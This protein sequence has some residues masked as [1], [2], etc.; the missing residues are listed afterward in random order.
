MAY[1]TVRLEVTGA[2]ATLTIERVDKLNALNVTVRRELIAALDVLAV[3]DQV[4]V[5]VLAGAGD[6]AFAAG[7]DV[8]E[9][10]ARTPDEQ[11]AVMEEYSLFD[12]VA[13]QPKP[14]IA[15]IRGFALGGGCELALACDIRVAARS[16]RLGLPEVR[17]G[18]LPG[19]GGTQR[20]PRLVGYGQALRLILTGD[21][22]DGEEAAHLGLVDVLV[23]DAELE[24]ATADLA[25]AIAA[26]SPVA[27]RAARQAV[28]AAL[29]L[30]LEAGL[31]REREL[32]L[33]AF[34]SEDGV[35]GV[36]AFLEK[37]PPSF[38]GR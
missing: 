37:R 6:K 19:G 22:I 2:I 7:A 5:I 20:L 28:H 4:R 35:E 18:L 36:R 23:D 29:E 31:R 16:A 10:A 34:A 3:D 38:R 17:L 1:E 8:A 33:Q 26:R 25:A 21:L 11:R 27:V 12:A 24:Q 30:P 9:F 15:R 32:F 14:T 13:G